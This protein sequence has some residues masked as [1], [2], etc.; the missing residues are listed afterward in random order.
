[1]HTPDDAITLTDN[2]RRALEQHFAATQRPP[3]RIFLSFLSESGPRLELT[4]DAP[5]PTDTTVSCSGWSFVV[6]NLLFQQAAPLLVDCDQ[7]GFCIHSQ[8]DF[9]E[10]GGDCGG[11]CTSH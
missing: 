6:N 8:L 3:L 9:S 7:T 4:P 11:H 10:A 2:A 1:M 5:T